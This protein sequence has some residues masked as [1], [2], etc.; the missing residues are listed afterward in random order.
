MSTFQ[1]V[2]YCIRSELVVGPYYKSKLE[3]KSS[4]SNISLLPVNCKFICG[5]IPTLTEEVLKSNFQCKKEGYKL[6]SNWQNFARVRLQLKFAYIIRPV[7]Y[8]NDVDLL[9]TK[10]SDVKLIIV[11]L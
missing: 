9:T 6:A 2:H 4:L 10:I 11:H 8:L 1:D 3:L 5:S 7:K